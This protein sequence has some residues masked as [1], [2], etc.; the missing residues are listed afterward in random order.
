MVTTI[1]YS[2]RIKAL[3]FDEP[4]QEYYDI[5]LLARTDKQNKLRYNYSFDTLSRCYFMT[6][7]CVDDFPAHIWGLENLGNQQ[8]ARAYFR[9]YTNQK[10]HHEISMNLTFNFYKDNPQ[11]HQQYVDTL[12]F[13]R[14]IEK[15]KTQVDSL[16]SRFGASYW[17]KYPTPLFYNNVLQTFY[18]WGDETRVTELPLMLSG[19][20]SSSTM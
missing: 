17:K 12:F 19:P 7:F 9:T 4:I 8:V 6:L 20:S 3:V 16:L 5:L 11:F 1:R 2:D 14:N 18:I 13:T 10:H 15:K